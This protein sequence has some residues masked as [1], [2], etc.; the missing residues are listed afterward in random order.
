MLNVGPAFTRRPCRPR[1]GGGDPVGLASVGGG[2]PVGLGSAG[3]TLHH[4]R[5]SARPLPGDPVDPE[6]PGPTLIRV[7]AL[8][9]PF[10][11]K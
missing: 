5:V 10:S 6:S 1:V 9:L 11:E 8:E 3:P 7:P 4:S 2:D